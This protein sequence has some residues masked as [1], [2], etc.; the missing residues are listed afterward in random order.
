MSDLS[1]STEEK[2]YA[3]TLWKV[4]PKTMLCHFEMVIA[5]IADGR[6]KLLWL[7]LGENM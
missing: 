2:V 1:D 3:M 5:Q 4:T 6:L 7:K